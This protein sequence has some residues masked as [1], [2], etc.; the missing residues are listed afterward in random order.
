ML[1]KLIKI[2]RTMKNI[3]LFIV[4]LISFS[5]MA[6]EKA[7]MRVA[8]YNLRLNT[9][10]DGKNAWPN[11]KEMVK[12]LILFHDFDIFGTQE[13]LP[14]QLKDLCEL[15][16]YAYVGAGRDDGKDSGEH[17]SIFY[18]K[19]R[20]KLLQSGN[21][22]LSTT[23]DV[24]SMGWDAKCC[25]RV[26]SW[27]KFKDNKT[28][29]E[30]YFFNVHFDHEGQIARIESGKLMVQKIK[31]IAG[32]APVI[33]TGDF[34]SN[35]ETEQIQTMQTL[36]NDAYKVTQMPPYGPVGTF[37]G[38]KTDFTPENR[39]DYIF[40]DNKFAVLKYGV[41]T[42][43]NNGRYPSDHYPIIADLKWEK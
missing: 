33:C 40:T 9:A 43:M 36:L 3:A 32:N 29:K 1:V 10:S 6:Q 20:F 13:G 19:D 21:F 35:P 14:D 24:P 34:N 38:F 22:W 15:N 2:V 17:S 41:L 4:C 37:T 26:C 39:I 7:D 8:S 5:T 28:K 11:R 16:T 42:D 12:A 18:K 25:K 31:E 23:P 27:G 30:F